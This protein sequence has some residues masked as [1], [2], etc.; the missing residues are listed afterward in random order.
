MPRLNLGTDGARADTYF[1]R[2]KLLELVSAS[3][4]LHFSQVMSERSSLTDSCKQV[5]GCGASVIDK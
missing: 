4:A 5:N 1:N 3:V 2:P